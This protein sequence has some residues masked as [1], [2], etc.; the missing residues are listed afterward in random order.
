MGGLYPRI[1]Q[2]GRFDAVILGWTIT[3][4]PDIFQ[5]WHSSQAHDGG[6]NFTHYKNPELDRLLEEARATPDQAA[7]TRLYARVQEILADD[8]PYCFLFVPYALP[9]VQRRFMGI[10]P[11]LAGIM[12][13]FD[14]WWVPKALQRYEVVE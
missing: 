8:Q 5:V 13:N 3:Q 1:R 14:K 9:V 2:Q 6:L 12:Y 11:A 4:D 10:R 7:R